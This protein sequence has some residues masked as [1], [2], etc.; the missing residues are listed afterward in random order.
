MKGKC[1]DKL[2]GNI[3]A[4]IFDYDGTV[5]DS[6]GMWGRASSDFVRNVLGREPEEGLDALVK[7]ISLE[8]SAA[9][10][11]EKYGAVG[12]EKEIVA[13]VLDSV[14]DR[15][16]TDLQL[17]PGV[18][19]VL[20]DLK[21]HGIRMC[22]ATA[23]LREMIEAGNSRL[24]LE[25][26]FEQ[27]FTCMEVGANKRKPDIYNKAAEYFGTAPEETL[28][29]ED[30]IHAARTASQAGYRLVGVYDRDSDREW[31]NIKSLSRI[32]LESFHDW[33]GIENY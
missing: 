28:V 6:M 8:Q 30:V 7:T 9:I 11:R 25:P 22:V 18:E 16:R 26:Y 10:F 33:K 29:F 12:T 14:I 24:G 4:A 15:Y 2:F 27:I 5:I 19:R 21:D 23:S 32:S 1:M 20:Q 3:K 17:K 13:Q 31:E